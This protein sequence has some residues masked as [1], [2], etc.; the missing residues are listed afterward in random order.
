MAH[1]NV[2]VQT[3]DKSNTS[4]R[5]ARGYRAAVILLLVHILLFSMFALSSCDTADANGTPAVVD[6]SGTGVTSPSATA[7]ALLAD[8]G[9]IHPNIWVGGVDIGGLTK[10]EALA[11]LEETLQNAFTDSSI[12]FL[13]NGGSMQRPF[14]DFSIALDLETAVKHAYAYT[15]EGDASLLKERATGLATMRFDVETG[16]FYDTGALVG[17]LVAIGEEVSR[18]PV[19]PSMRRENGEFVFEPGQPGLQIDTDGTM[20]AFTDALKAFR[21]DDATLEVVIAIAEEAP[22]LSEDDLRQATSLLGTWTTKF[23][24]SDVNRTENLRLSSGSVNNTY[25]L[26]GEIFSTNATFGETTAANGYKPGGAYLNGKLVDSIGGGV[27]QTSSTLYRALLEAELEIVER[28]NHSLPVGYM[29]LGFDATL[30]GD[31]IDMKFKNSTDMPILLETVMEGGSLTVNIYGKETRDPARRIEFKNEL[32]KTI[33]PPEEKVT[34][35][36]TLP[37]NTRVVD[38]AAKTGYEYKVYKQIFVNGVLVETVPVNTSRYR[39][40]AAEVRVGTGPAATQQ[41]VQPEQPE[42]PTQP[43]VQPTQPPEQPTQPPVQPT[44]P[45]VAT[46]EPDGPPPMSLEDYL[47]GQH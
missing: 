34:E 38:A 22:A 18:P 27:C 42:Q 15:R 31:Y 12:L 7:D 28:T 26:P 5:T 47:R 19:E 37:L 1:N 30:A 25:M 9:R 6:A 8:D 23:A 2:R 45:P 17:T 13:Y 20:D 41:P 3:K 32:V 4:V 33:D 39:A 11:K 21:A 36:P 46:P 29:V 43:P 35:D 24:A 40:V 10:E 44:M 16:C 14:R